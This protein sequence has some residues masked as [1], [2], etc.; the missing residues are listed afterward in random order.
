M[1]VGFRFW[2]K[3]NLTLGDR[4]GWALAVKYLLARVCRLALAGWELSLLIAVGFLSK[5]LEKA[6]WYRKGALTRINFYC[7]AKTCIF[8]ML[9]DIAHSIKR[10]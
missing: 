5:T 7:I 1:N 6:N 9:K 10:L 8:Q 4:L 2:G 3:R